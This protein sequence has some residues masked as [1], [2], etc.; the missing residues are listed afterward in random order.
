M[1]EEQR[2]FAAVGR[3]LVRLADENEQLREQLSRAIEQIKILESKLGNEQIPQ[4]PVS[5]SARGNATSK[6]RP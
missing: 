2:T 5:P 3:Q 6:K 4:V 1:N